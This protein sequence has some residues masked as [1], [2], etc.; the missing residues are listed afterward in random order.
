MRTSRLALAAAIL[1]IAG[2]CARTIAPAPRRHDA[3][4]SGLR[5][6]GAHRRRWRARTL[7]ALQQ[8][9]W[10]FLQAGDLGEARR[11][12]SAA[13]AESS[14]FYP[15]DAGLAYASLADHDYAD[16][17]RPVRPRA[18]PRR[19]LCA[20]HGRE[21][22]RPGGRGP[23]RRR[24][25]ACSPRSSP[26]IRRWRDV[27][28]RL[29]VL[30]FRA[31]Q[32]VLKG[33]RQAADAGRFDE[34]VA[35]YERAI[36][37]SPDSALLYR[38]LAAVERKADRSDAALAHL[39]KA[40]VLDPSEARGFVQL[41]ELLEERGDFAGAVDAYVKAEAIEPGDEARSR[42]AAARSR[43]DLARLPEEYRAIGGA[44]Q[45]T[46]GD[47]AALIGVRLGA[48][49]KAATRG[50]GAVVT[51]VR[52]HWAS[53]WIMAVVRAGV[54]EPYPNHAFAPRGVVR[55]LDLAQAASRV[56]GLIAEREAGTGARVAGG[57]AADHRSAGR[58]LGVSCCG[59]GGRR[60][61]HAARRRRRL[62]ADTGRRRGRSHRRRDPSRGAGPMTAWTI[63][64]QLTLLRMGLIPAF[65]I[66]VVYGRP[67]WALATFVV[68][69][70]TDGLDGLIARRAG[71]QTSLGAWL[72]PMADKL[73][74]VTT[75]V[76]LTVPGTDLTNRFPLWLTILVI[77]RDVVIVTTVAIVT[78]VMGVRT[79]RPS[80]FGK[81]ATAVYVV[82]CVILLWFNYLG[83]T[84]VLVDAGIW[85]SLAITLVSGFHYV[86]HAARIINSPAGNKQ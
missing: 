68:A 29:D 33:A 46:R 17:D 10:Q 37:A 79:F 20:G 34:A 7:V 3:P 42:V 85:I 69:G 27:R 49:L 78:A 84:S 35:G 48:L 80:I 21:G 71:Q 70:I 74:L 25:R 5:V 2:G 64:N 56:L 81:A 73:L 41:G 66:M 54:M 19:R 6:S 61:R 63:A 15:A 11:A 14:R 26:S 60:G 59:D 83:R 28:R 72:D 47:L 24:H 32:V 52:S 57:A 31:Q 86:A 4:L 22:R 16:A 1:A 23:D 36:A 39:K 9:G 53:P 77:S 30:A 43:A 12:F 76:V 50:E 55:R 13:L 8:R 18:A 75:F 44:A 40:V 67:G 62:Q 45:V 65:V 51:D 82:T 38:E 58:P